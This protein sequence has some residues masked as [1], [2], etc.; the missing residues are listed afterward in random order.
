MPHTESLPILIVD[1]PPFHPHAG[2]RHPHEIRTSTVEATLVD[3]SAAKS[4]QTWPGP[5]ERLLR[6]KDE[7]VRLWQHY[8]IGDSSAKLWGTT[9]ACW[10]NLLTLRSST[11]AQSIDE[12]RTETSGHQ[13]TIN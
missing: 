2:Q 9:N 8:G 1:D 6:R 10:R 7:A 13:K 3:N 12:G 4:N 11:V 5:S